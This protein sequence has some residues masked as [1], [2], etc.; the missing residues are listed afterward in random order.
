[1][2]Y[3]MNV[4]AAH[5]KT[6]A[7]SH[8]KKHFKIKIQEFKE[9]AA[10]DP[11]SLLDISVES[12]PEWVMDAAPIY[13]I[14]QESFLIETGGKLVMQLTIFELKDRQYA[15]SLIEKLNDECIVVN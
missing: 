15:D 8:S 14:G 9:E 1:M 12:V 6:P 13:T 4:V 5:V 11:N 10:S 7:M 2:Y 3:F